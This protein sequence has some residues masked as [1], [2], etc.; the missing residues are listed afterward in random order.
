MLDII[1]DEQW[2]TLIQAEV[3]AFTTDRIE[4]RSFGDDIKHPAGF[5]LIVR[6]L[7]EE[8]AKRRVKKLLASPEWTAKWAADGQQQASVAVQ[9][10]VTEHAAEIL[11]KWVS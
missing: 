11:N 5:K 1:P 6:G 3:A 9:K 4:R 7:L 10:Y 2:N 8:D